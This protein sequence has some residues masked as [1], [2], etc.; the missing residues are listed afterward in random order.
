MPAT[1]SASP[2]P[3]RPA[4]SA[5]GTPGPP[6]TASPSASPQ[7]PPREPTFTPTEPTVPGRLGIAADLETDADKDGYGD[8]TQDG[9]PSQASHGAACD[10]RAPQT[11]ITA[12][13]ASGRDRSAVLKFRSDESA[14]T[15]ACSLDGGAY[16]ACTSPAGATVR[17]GT[18]RV[19]G[20]RHRP[21][22]QPRRHPGLR[23][24]DR[25]LAPTPGRTSEQRR[26]GL[27]HQ[28]TELPVPAG[29]RVQVVVEVVDV[30]LGHRDVRR[31]E[32]GRHPREGCVDP[33]DPAGP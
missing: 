3:R 11:T 19:P 14:S 13:P 29:G 6:A 20:A 22:G 27:G 12:R 7:H 32:P 10:R 2:S 15:F 8:V 21:V 17:R 24:L 31:P 4:G 9:C 30:D 16:R 33:R 28:V 26:D 1:C 18:P 5:A 25:P 23:D